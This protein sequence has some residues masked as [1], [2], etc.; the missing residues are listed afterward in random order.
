MSSIT[1]RAGPRLHE[2][3]CQSAGFDPKEIGAQAEMA[4]RL[5]IDKSR[6]ARAVI[7]GVQVTLDKLLEWMTTWNDGAHGRRIAFRF[8]DDG[9]PRFDVEVPEALTDSS[10]A[11]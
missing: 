5:A 11:G 1:E 3:F 2:A 8:D 4:R 7:Q 6:Y 10:P 9:E